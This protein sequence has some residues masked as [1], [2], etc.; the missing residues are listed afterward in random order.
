MPFLAL[1]IQRVLVAPEYGLEC[2]S[3]ALVIHMNPIHVKDGHSYDEG[4]Q[5][6]QA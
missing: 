3:L 6:F 2:M 1:L 5:A 4:L